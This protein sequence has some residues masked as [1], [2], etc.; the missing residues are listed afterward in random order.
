[1]SSAV[2]KPLIQQLIDVCED[3]GIAFVDEQMS[4]VGGLSDSVQ[5]SYD[6]GVATGLLLGINNPNDNH[7]SFLISR[8][9]GRLDGKYSNHHL[10]QI[11]I[12]ERLVAG[13]P[14][15]RRRSRKTKRSRSKCSAPKRK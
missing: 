5:E 10:V 4:R 7:Y 11:A 14:G 3:D 6:M 8:A 2:G 9:M 12:N 13:K 1:M 15:G